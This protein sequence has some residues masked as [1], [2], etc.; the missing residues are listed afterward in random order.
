V[1][2]VLHRMSL[3]EMCV[4]YGDPN[5]PYQRKCAFDVSF[6][7]WFCPP[8][9][10]RQH[11]E[12]TTRHHD[13]WHVPNWSRNLSLIA[14]SLQGRLKSRIL[15]SLHGSFVACQINQS[16]AAVATAGGRLR[17][18]VLLQQPGAGLRLPGHH[19]VLRRRHDRLQGYEGQ[20]HPER[21][22]KPCLAIGGCSPASASGTASATSRRPQQFAPHEL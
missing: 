5:P 11:A 1:R 17:A 3:V 15:L 16:D 4:P 8:S 14:L 9:H 7:F 6:W 20:P 18:G 2:P 22:L 10:H 12:Q 13:R 21:K 19:Q